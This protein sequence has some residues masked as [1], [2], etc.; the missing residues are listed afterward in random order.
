VAL[1][2]DAELPRVVEMEHYHAALRRAGGA[3]S[4]AARTATVAFLTAVTAE[5][6]E[7][8]TGLRAHPAARRS[9]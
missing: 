7:A 6:S 1:R 4:A 2:S 8:A 5:A 9:G 3:L